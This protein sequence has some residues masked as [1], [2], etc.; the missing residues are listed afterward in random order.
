MTESEP[1]SWP[2]ST[3]GRR[4]IWRTIREEETFARCLEYLP[5]DARRVD[6]SLDSLKWKLARNAE[7][8]SFPLTGRDTRITFVE[9]ASDD[10]VPMRVLFWI[11]GDVVCLAWIEDADDE[12]PFGWDDF[13]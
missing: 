12:S 3:G 8:C 10:E 1:K 6:E 9:A 4:P 2:L 13:L 5:G 11:E 7:G